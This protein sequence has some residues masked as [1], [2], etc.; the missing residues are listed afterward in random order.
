MISAG[1]VRVDGT[2]LG[3]AMQPLEPGDPHRIG[4]YAL[5]GR[6][7]AGGMGTVFLGHAR[8]GGLVAIKTVQPH[9]AQ[10]PAFRER[11]RREVAAARQLE[12]RWTAAVVDADC[13]ASIPWV[14]SVYIDAPDVTRMVTERGPLPADSVQAL[15]VGLADALAAIH[16]AGLVHRDVKPSNVLLT[17]DGPRII[18]FGIAKA[19]DMGPALTT[20]GV[21]LGTPGYF[22][23]EQALGDATTAA[24]DIFGLGATLTYAATGHG[25]FT[26]TSASALLYR[27]VHDDPDLTDVPPIL[28]PTLAACLD[29]QPHRRPTP[30]QLRTLL[31]PEH[32][33]HDRFATGH[34]QP[35]R[36]EEFLD[37]EVEDERPP[38]EQPT[39]SRPRD[40]VPPAP[41]PAEPATAQPQIAWWSLGPDEYEEPVDEAPLPYGRALIEERERRRQEELRGP[42]PGPRLVDAQIG[43]VVEHPKFGI[44]TI[45]NLSDYP[46]PKALAHIVFTSRRY[47]EQRLILARA[48]LRLVGRGI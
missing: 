28:L 27:V 7:G 43:D 24:S 33:S 12:E 9:I 32:A 40:A 38:W 11:F 3:G 15:G 45:V 37:D 39:R 29:K 41:R 35:R 1:T 13:E 4:P 26:A 46:G 36:L 5:A 10:R 21:V 23:P 42:A 48:P 8:D 17:A 34:T 2:Q 47:G 19:H 6:L 18:D 31:T 22:A 44:G 20:V 14:A 16:A 25:P 30:H